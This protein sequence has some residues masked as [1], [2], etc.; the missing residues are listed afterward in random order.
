MPTST[1]FFPFPTTVIPSSA[2]SLP[3][4]TKFLI[5]KLLS[6]IS[7][8][9]AL[10]PI[11]LAASNICPT[12]I[13]KNSTSSVYKVQFYD[14]NFNEN[15]PAPVISPT[16]ATGRSP[17][18]LARPGF[19]GSFLRITNCTSTTQQSCTHGSCYI[20]YLTTAQIL[21]N[22]LCLTF[23]DAQQNATFS[24]QPCEPFANSTT[25]L[26]KLSQVVNYS[27]AYAAI[28]KINQV[29]VNIIQPEQGLGIPFRA[30]FLAA[31]VRTIEANVFPYT[32]AGLSVRLV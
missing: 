2:F 28:T 22:R 32:Q 12:F 16:N 1:L 9:L 13:A 18:A 17:W 4:S 29:D 3:S 7:T 15:S 31:D 5:M 19:D 27:P 25:Q 24:F 26:F 10:L 21:R 8:F 23:S 30:W 20:N 14:N 6:T 11:A